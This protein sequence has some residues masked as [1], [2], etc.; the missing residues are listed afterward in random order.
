MKAAARI[1]VSALIDAASTASAADLPQILDVAMASARAHGISLRMLRRELR[2]ALRTTDSTLVATLETIAGD[3]GAEAA[4]IAKALE[5]HA[6]KK[7]DLRQKASPILG[8]AILALG[9]DRLDAS[10][11]AAL[12]QAERTLSTPSHA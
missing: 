7:V 11:A 8:G 12:R 4:A 6:G 1:L 2:R 3:A 9:D 10:L 5:Q